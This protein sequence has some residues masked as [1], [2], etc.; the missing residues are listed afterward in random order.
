MLPSPKL[1]CPRCRALVGS[2]DKICPTCGIELELAAALIEREA[3][4]F[5]PETTPAPYVADIILPR[6]GAYLVKS[7][8]ITEDQLQIALDQQ[9]RLA[10]QGQPETIGQILLSQGVIT[11]ERLD[12]ASVRQVQELQS[13]LIKANEELQQ[14]I[15]E[16]TRDLHLALKRLGELNALKAN[17]VSNISH[18]LRT[19]VAQ[20]QGYAELLER[21]LFG[22]LN[23]EQI[24]AVQVILRSGERLRILIDDLLRF[25]TSMQG[26]MT[27]EW[28]AVDLVTLLDEVAASVRA[29]VNAAH[30]S[31]ET[32]LPPQAVIGRID[33]GK[34]RWV[35]NQLLDNAIKFTPQTGRVQLQ[36]EAG[37]GEIKI[38]VMDTGIGIAAEALPAIFAPF[39]QLDGSSTRRFG[40]TG[41]GLAIV[42]RIV[43]AHRGRLDVSSQ[44]NQGSQFSLYLPLAQIKPAEHGAHNPPATV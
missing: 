15:N 11:R 8:Y 19:P 44:P 27:L 4:A 2:Q 33:P 6:F 14:G 36:V 9:Q 21:G 35:V 20:M 13:A 30:L 3:L 31:L 18:E 38:S 34:I 1:I 43:E 39:Y 23:K 24:E 28:E 7:S 32:D 10:Q 5:T 22:D 37:S 17:F 41:L 40:G 29:R 12:R 16:R 42:K 25:A 26:E